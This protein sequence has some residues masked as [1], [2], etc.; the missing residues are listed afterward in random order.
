MIGRNNQKEL[1]LGKLNDHNKVTSSGSG[2]DDDDVKMKNKGI[3]DGA[4][5]LLEKVGISSKSPASSEMVYNKTYER[6]KEDGTKSS[7]LN[8][9][10]L[11]YGS[12]TKEGDHCHIQSG[13]GR[14]LKNVNSS[15]NDRNHYQQQQ[16]Q[17]Q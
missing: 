3:D 17:Q 10:V 13:G 2:Y 15:N 16:Q 9:R 11:N 8:E 14:Q 6:E 5:G 1:G 4:E 7:T 12:I